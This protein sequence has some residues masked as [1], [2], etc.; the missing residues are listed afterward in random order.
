M[1]DS[2][3]IYFDFNTAKWLGQDT[4]EV[5]KIEEESHIVELVAKRSTDK[6]FKTFTHAAVEFDQLEAAKSKQENDYV[7]H[8]SS[9]DPLFA[10]LEWI[11]SIKEEGQKVILVIVQ[12]Y[13]HKL[14]KVFMESGVTLPEYIVFFNALSMMGKIELIG[15]LFLIKCEFTKILPLA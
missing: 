9:L 14:K 15:W 7:I 4:G 1:N 2:E 8:H 11:D 3:I 10:F 5:D 13:F 12:F 6:R